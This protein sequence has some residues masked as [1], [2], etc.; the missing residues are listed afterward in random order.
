MVCDNMLCRGPTVVNGCTE[1]KTVDVRGL[2]ITDWS[3][4]DRKEEQIFS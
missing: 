3:E 1:L 4:L 2:L